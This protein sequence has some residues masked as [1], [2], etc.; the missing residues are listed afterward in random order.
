M[1]WHDDNLDVRDRLYQIN[2]FQQHSQ[3]NLLQSRKS[4]SALVR[5]KYF[6]IY[7]LYYEHALRH[8]DS[9]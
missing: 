6:Q 8:Y 2:Y 3:N 7:S 1:E 4:H 9:L 5:K